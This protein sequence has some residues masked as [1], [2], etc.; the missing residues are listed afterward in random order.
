MVYLLINILKLQAFNWQHV[1]YAHQF[2]QLSPVSDHRPQPVKTAATL[3]LYSNTT[4]AITQ[5]RLDK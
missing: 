5:T 2:R 3:E 1:P 4:P